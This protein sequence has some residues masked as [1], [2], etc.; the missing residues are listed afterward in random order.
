MRRG[1]SVAEVHSTPLHPRR[2]LSNI[3]GIPLGS[4]GV[5]AIFLFVA[6]F[7]ELIAPYDPLETNVAVRLQ[8]PALLGGDWTHPL[9]TDTAGRDILSRLMHGARLSLVVA[10]ATLLIGGGVG[11][12][13]GMLSGYAGGRTDSVLMRITDLTLS[14]PIIL[15]AL[16]LAAALGPSTMNVVIAVSCV[17]WAQFARVIR[18]ETLVY[19]EQGYVALAQVAGAST[20]H[21][22]R[23]HI[24]PNVA[25]TVLVL[26]TLQMGWVVIV[27]ASLSF[28]GAGVP[29][30]EPAWGSMTAAGRDFVVSAWWVP[31]M[32]GLAIML[33]VLSLNLFGDWLRD[34]L[35][36]R[37][38]NL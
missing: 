25:N 26:A 23:V 11:T 4:L 5:L 35:D 34:K 18:A 31:A 24:L 8:P 28:L 14:Y 37:L 27:E 29:P 38:R 36:P 1:E 6:L 2:V 22:L 30:P 21:I 32:P 13:L 9:G 12:A 20:P 7:A 10:V 16:L 19:R 17:L 3:L 15:L 33:V